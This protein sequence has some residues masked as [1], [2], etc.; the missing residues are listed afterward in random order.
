MKLSYE[1]IIKSN[2]CIEKFNL[3]NKPIQEDNGMFKILAW[4]G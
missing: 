3:T 4:V 2:V 1:I